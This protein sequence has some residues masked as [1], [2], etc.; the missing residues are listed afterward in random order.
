[1][2]PNGT[3]LSWRDVHKAVERSEERVLAAIG[4]VH[5]DVKDHELRLRSI[6]QFGTLPLQAVKL[7]VARL[8]TR[9]IP[10]ENDRLSASGAGI[11][12]RRLAGLANRS[13]AIIILVSNFIV[14]GVV[15]VVNL[16]LSAKP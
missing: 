7:D 11:E 16:L 4:E 10:I 1:M 9:L 13:L 14:S 12:R 3:P 8:D 5:A 2:T 6:E 15:V